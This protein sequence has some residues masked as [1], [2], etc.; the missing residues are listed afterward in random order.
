MPRGPAVR[1]PGENEEDIAPPLV[2]AA[3]EDDK[4]DPPAPPGAG[5]RV[6]ADLLMLADGLPGCV[7]P[8]A[9]PTPVVPFPLEF[10]PG[11]MP[12]F[13]S[14][15]TELHTVQRYSG[16][17]P[18]RTRRKKVSR[19]SSKKA[20]VKP[21]E[22]ILSHFCLDKAELPG[23]LLV[24]AVEEVVILAVELDAGGPAIGLSMFPLLERRCGLLCPSRLRGIVG[25]ALLFV[26]PP[27][28]E[29]AA[30]DP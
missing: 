10:V 22:I 29:P 9:A 18:R 13:C 25:G 20:C 3:V 14:F 17:M 24:A 7:P 8:A 4:V 26:V 23:A 12:N 15:M 11:H 21:L 28:V 2:P 30:E 5:L 19:F 27:E 1:E 6:P 16:G